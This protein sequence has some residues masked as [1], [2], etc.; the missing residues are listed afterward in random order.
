MEKPKAKKLFIIFGIVMGIFLLTVFVKHLNGESFCIFKHL[1]GIPCPGCGISR[2]LAAIFTGHFVKACQ[3][4]L[5]SYP[6][7][8]GS[9]I[10]VIWNVVD[11]LK[12]KD[13]YLE[14][15]HR[16]KLNPILIVLLVIFVLLNWVHNI[17]LGL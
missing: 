9:F 8:I 1:T 6:I 16:I 15:F 17:Y 10:I 4:N 2:G 11:L 13:T 5:L 12:G 7:A 14:A 3:Y